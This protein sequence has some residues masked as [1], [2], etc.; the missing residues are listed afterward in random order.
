MS[1]PP[2]DPVPHYR[3]PSHPFCAPVP[4]FVVKKG[5]AGLRWFRMCVLRWRWLDAAS[6]HLLRTGV[7]NPMSR[8]PARPGFF[9]D[10]RAAA[11]PYST[12]LVY[13]V[14]IFFFPVVMLWYFFNT[15]PKKR[16]GHRRVS[17]NT[18]RFQSGATFRAPRLTANIFMSWLNFNLC[19]L[20][21][22]ATE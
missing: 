12:L 19:C 3:P 2:G 4:I 1:C 21:L 9:E 15:Q 6:R 8:Y 16:P 22:M 5:P 14:N 7:A 10:Q 11:G 13:T 20:L 17:V 18:D